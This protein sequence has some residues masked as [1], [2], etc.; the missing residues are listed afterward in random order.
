MFSAGVCA[1]GTVASSVSGPVSVAVRRRNVV[2]VAVAAAVAVDLG[3]RH[4][5][6]RRVGP[7]LA[8]LQQ[9]V[10]VADRVGAAHDRARIRIRIGHHNPGQRRVA[11]VG[12][13]DRVVERLARHIRD[14]PRH[15]LLDDVQRR[16]LRH[17]HRRIV[18][19]RT[20][21]VAVRRR[22]VVDVAVA[23]AV[24]VDLGL[25]HRVRRRVGPGLADLQ[26]GVVVADRVGAAH[27]RARIRIRIGHHNPGQRRVA[28]VRLP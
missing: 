13:R 20:G 18:G 16:G 11:G 27:D 3:L 22:N 6:R 17:R 1:T 21:L 7:G 24:A 23:A 26:Q 4:R 8:D 10:V 12:Y 15:R 9:G 19:V 25:R 2:D 5:V 14:L 28:G